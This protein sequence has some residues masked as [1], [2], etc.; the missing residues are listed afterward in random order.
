[1]MAISYC[2]LDGSQECLNLIVVN[3][4]G[5]NFLNHH[6]L[7]IVSL[8][9]NREGCTTAAGK[10]RVTFL[11]RQFDIS[12]MIILAANDNDVLQAADHKQLPISNEPE[13]AC[14]QEGPAGIR[15]EVRRKYL[16][17][18]H[19][20]FEISCGYAISCNPDFTDSVRAALNHSFGI[21]YYDF[22]ALYDLTY[23]YH[24]LRTRI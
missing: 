13:I 17:C 24:T 19:G 15:T 3:A 8:P 20:V 16:A 12:G 9:Y 23:T 2:R 7:F 1:M 5:I 10:R 6:Q 11:H 22:L 14:A 18:S 4:N 21:G